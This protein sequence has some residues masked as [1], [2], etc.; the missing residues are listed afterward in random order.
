MYKGRKK[1]RTI[2]IWEG[3]GQTGYR[4]FTYTP[5]AIIS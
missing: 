5:C 1:N 2:I 3:T 4:R